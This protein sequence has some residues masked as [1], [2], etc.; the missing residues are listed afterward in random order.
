MENCRIVKVE[1]CLNVMHCEASA[2]FKIEEENLD[3]W[4]ISGSFSP[5][6][7]FLFHDLNWFY[8]F[9]VQ[10]IIYRNLT[11]ILRMQFISY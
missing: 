11:F 2:I 6:V 7:L 3:I 4:R 10:F 1:D 5:P 8:R 9:S